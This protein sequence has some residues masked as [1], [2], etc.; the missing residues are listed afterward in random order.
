MDKKI[1]LI[2]LFYIKDNIIYITSPNMSSTTLFESSTIIFEKASVVFDSSEL[3]TKLTTPFENNYTFGILKLKA[4]KMECPDKSHHFVFTIDRSG[5][6]T[7]TCAD[8]RTKQQHIA[9]TFK[10]MLGFFHDHPHIRVRI[11][12]FLFDY[13][14]VQILD[15]VIITSENIDAIIKKIDLIRP[16]GD[17]NIGLAIQTA[18][19]FVRDEILLREI[20]SEV[21]HIFMTD[22]D[23][24]TGEMNPATL[25][26]NVNNTFKNVFVGF[27]IEHNDTI[28]NALSSHYNSAYYFIDKLENSGLVY[29]EIL[30]SLLYKL[31]VNIEIKIENGLLYDFK[32][33]LW[34][35][36]L[37]VG[38]IVGEADKTYHIVSENPAD[39]VI[40]IAGNKF[41]S[42]EFVFLP[43][44]NVV[45]EDNLT[46]YV[47]RQKTLQLLHEVKDFSN[48]E[49][50]K[51]KNVNA[52]D[53]FQKNNYVNVESDNNK[54]IKNY[55]DKMKS[56]MEE[57]KQY[58][59]ENGLENDNFMKNLCD[60]VYVCYR[61]FGTAYSGMYTNARLVS[62]GTQR[63][64]T[65]S[66]TPD[67]E[68]PNTVFHNMNA[69]LVGTFNDHVL[70]HF[71]DTPYSSPTALELMRSIS[72]GNDNFDNDCNDLNDG[73]ND[74]D[75]DRNSLY[76]SPCSCEENS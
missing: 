35:R 45:F 41:D 47:F 46:C 76:L 1:E 52:W 4:V 75:N 17:T 58:M 27:G 36:T 25:K 9:H 11:S 71:H 57:M 26:K 67:L 43:V 59:T 21:S 20:D 34:A 28:L 32:N 33:D 70:S 54:I 55:R 19:D 14:V 15:R 49:K 12:I 18:N 50:E 48:K 7:D 68:L 56:L 60:D 61:T 69:S 72:D 62:Q 16:R 6:M 30:H 38:D 39:C 5:S 73:D 44:R 51:N 2:I 24:T 8:G 29:G 74:N 23:A 65:V 53:Y 22:G 40:H 3:K 37:Y 63:C 13:E 64:Y 42:K 10:N 66:D 31:L